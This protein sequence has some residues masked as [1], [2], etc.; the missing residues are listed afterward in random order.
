MWKLTQFVS[1]NDRAAISDWRKSMP[2]GPFKA[3]LDTFLANMVKLEQ[4]GAPD[5]KPMTGNLKGLHELR[6]K[7]GRVQHRI[8]GRLTGEQEFLMLIGCTHK[9]DVYDPPSALDTALERDRKIKNQ[10]ASISEY[11]FLTSK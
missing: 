2:R 9:D 11:E 8:I 5:F 10:E 6:W 7:A 1:G 3:T 4:W